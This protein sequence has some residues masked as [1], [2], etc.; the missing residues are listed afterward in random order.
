MELQRWSS[1]TEVLQPLPFN[2]S[3]G[4]S[5]FSDFIWPNQ[6]RQ[7]HNRNEKVEQTWAPGQWILVA[8]ETCCRHGKSKLPWTS[9]RRREE[10]AQGTHSKKW[11]YC[12]Y[13]CN[14][15]NTLLGDATQSPGKSAFFSSLKMAIPPS[16]PLLSL[17]WIFPDDRCPVTIVAIFSFNFPKI[18]FNFPPIFSR[19]KIG[20][21]LGLCVAFLEVF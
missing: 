1:Y 6:S 12:K 2:T 7:R 4:H 9:Q 20:D 3:I 17:V 18:K 14:Q 11:C 16:L 13:M 15:L 10:S 19:L 5:F 8:S 21:F